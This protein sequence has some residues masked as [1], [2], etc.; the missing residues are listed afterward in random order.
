LTFHRRRAR[1]SQARRRR[2][3][4]DLIRS[5][6]IINNIKDIIRVIIVSLLLLL[7]EEQRAR[8]TLRA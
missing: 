3:F 2:R 4:F 1:F 5:V 6:K 7:H 8:R